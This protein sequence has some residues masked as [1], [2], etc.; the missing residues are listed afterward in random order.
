[1]NT[2]YRQTLTKSQKRTFKI[3]QETLNKMGLK[4][5]HYVSVPEAFVIIDFEYKRLSNKRN[6]EE[7]CLEITPH[8]RM[9]LEFPDHDSIHLTEKNIAEKIQ[10]EINLTSDP[11]YSPLTKGYNP[12]TR[13]MSDEMFAMFKRMMADPLT[14]VPRLIL[15]DAPQP[16]ILP[17][18]ILNKL[19]PY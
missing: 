5:R 17:A 7:C 18:R 2:N 8:G 1:M 11:T 6:K 19:S 9:Y 16:E 4:F 12:K 15:Q 13:E 14:P 10:E 3:V